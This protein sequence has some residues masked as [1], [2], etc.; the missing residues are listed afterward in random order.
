MNRKR[1]G[2]R[3][4]TAA[5]EATLREAIGRLTWACA[6]AFPPQYSIDP[7]TFV[8]A[9]VDTAAHTVSALYPLNEQGQMVEWLQ[10]YMAHAVEHWRTDPTMMAFRKRRA[11]RG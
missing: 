10:N 8:H 11:D 3:M 9:L 1:S 4:G 6:E 2:L 5:D 7:G